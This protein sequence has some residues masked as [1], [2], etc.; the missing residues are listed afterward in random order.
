MN[1]EP[2][3][4]VIEPW[5]LVVLIIVLLGGLG[6]F[7]WYYLMG[8]GKVADS[9]PS[10]TPTV[11]TTPLAM[12][13]SSTTDW[14]TYT[15]SAYGFSIKYPKDLTYQ[16]NDN[17]KN[18]FFQTAKERAA[19]EACLQREATECISGNEITINVDKESGTNNEDD[20]SLA[21][22][23]II[24]NKVKNQALAQNPQKITF[25]SQPAYEGM[26]FG[27]LTW[28]GIITKYNNHVYDLTILCDADVLAICK[29]KIT[30]NQNKMIESFQFTK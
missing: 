20:V 9:T 3:K 10:S 19:Y 2:T 5:L 28:Y 7:A 29:G 14:K 15:N 24:Q 30:E 11:T 4:R 6:F 16:E 13:S 1:Q 21:L 8:S 12:D 17:G 25:A 27:M 23:E 22:D 18:V 26:E